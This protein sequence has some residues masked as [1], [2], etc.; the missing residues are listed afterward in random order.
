[1]SEAMGH[2]NYDRGAATDF[3]VRRTMNKDVA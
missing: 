3:S 2:R 1:M